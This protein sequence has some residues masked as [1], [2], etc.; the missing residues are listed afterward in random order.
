MNTLEDVISFHCQQASHIFLNHD[1]NPVFS[2]LEVSVFL[3]DFSLFHPPRTLSWPLHLCITMNLESHRGSYTLLTFITIIFI[4]VFPLSDSVSGEFTPFS[5][6]VTI[7]LSILDEAEL[8]RPAGY[9]HLSFSRAPSKP[10]PP[11]LHLSFFF[12]PPSSI[13]YFHRNL[14]I[15]IYIFFNIKILMDLT[16]FPIAK[17]PDNKYSHGNKKLK[18]IFSVSSLCQKVRINVLVFECTHDYSIFRLWVICF[19]CSGAN[20]RA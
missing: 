16:P 5:P 13:M 2:T 4:P 8:K 18:S 19:D 17:K 12:F 3:C 10:Q 20:H 9:G 11:T 6:T 14:T 15:I 7:S 1:I